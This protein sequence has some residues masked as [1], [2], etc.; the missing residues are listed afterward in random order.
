MT[1]LHNDSKKIYIEDA[2]DRLTGSPKAMAAD[3]AYIHDGRLYETFYKATLTAANT[4]NIGFL[5]AASKYVHYRPSA[6][7]SSGDLVTIYLYESAVVYSASSTLSSYNH[8]RNVTAAATAIVKVASTVSAA[9]TLISQ[10]FIGG[11]T[12]VG[13]AKS[14]AERGDVNEWVLQPSTQYVIKVNNGSAAS[15]TIQVNILWYEEDHG[16]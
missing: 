12:G 8:N 4:F 15:N 13:G 9:G 5:T 11:G 1:M 6:V 2:F 10:S 7:S 16:I 14:G 3:H